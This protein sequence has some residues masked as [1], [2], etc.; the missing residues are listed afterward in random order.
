MKKRNKRLPTTLD[1]AQTTRSPVAL[2]AILRSG[3]GPHTDKR[4]SR[5]HRDDWKR[6]VE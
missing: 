4:R 2:A 3:G 6:E 1:L 5:R